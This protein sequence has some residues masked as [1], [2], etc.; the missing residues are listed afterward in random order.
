[1]ELEAKIAA[2]RNAAVK[3]KQMARRVELNLEIKGLEKLF[4]GIFKSLSM[5][6]ATMKNYWQSANQTFTISGQT[7]MPIVINS[8]MWLLRVA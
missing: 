2:L 1:M 7:Y 5:P 8:D 6:Y 3:E 4:K